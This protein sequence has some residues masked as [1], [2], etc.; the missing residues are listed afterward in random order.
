MSPK[1]ILKQDALWKESRPIPLEP[2]RWGKV[3][4]ND[5]TFLDSN[6]VIQKFLE[7][8]T[9]QASYY[10][11]E[12]TLKLIKDTSLKLGSDEK[13][14]LSISNDLSSKDIV[15]SWLLNSLYLIPKPMPRWKSI[16]KKDCLYRFLDRTKK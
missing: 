15:S 4:V 9:F 3:Q 1:L 6:P 14:L 2:T 13:L 12:V 16:S 11:S 7:K 8:N 5:N 10:N